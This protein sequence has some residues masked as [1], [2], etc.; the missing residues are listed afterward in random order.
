MQRSPHVLELAIFKVKQECVAQVPVLRAGL[1]ETLKTFPGLIEY[2]IAPD[3]LDPFKLHNGLEIQETRCS[4]M[5]ASL[6]QRVH[7]LKSTLSFGRSSTESENT[8][9]RE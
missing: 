5:D 1:R 2:R 6:F 4:S 3:F 8:S 7:F 9:G